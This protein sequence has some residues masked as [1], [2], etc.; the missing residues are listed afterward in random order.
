[1]KR[2]MDCN[3]EYI[4]QNGG[5]S[6]VVRRVC[7]GDMFRVP[8]NLVRDFIEEGTRQDIT[9]EEVSPCT[10][11]CTATHGGISVSKRD[12]IF[13]GDVSYA[14]PSYVL[15]GL[16]RRNCS[17]TQKSFGSDV[18]HSAEVVLS[19]KT[20]KLV[21]TELHEKNIFPE[22]HAPFCE[23]RFTPAQFAML[24]TNMNIGDGVPGTLMKREGKSIRFQ[25]HKE[26][27][28]LEEGMSYFKKVCKEQAEK[29][30]ELA[31]TVDELLE[32][33]NLTKED[34]AKL[35]GAITSARRTFDDS[36]PFAASQFQRH[37]EKV[38]TSAK[39]D[40][41][42]AMTNAMVGLGRDALLAG[43]DKPASGLPA[44]V[45]EFVSLMRNEDEEGADKDD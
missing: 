1:M 12:N 34:R 40:I 45:H 43:G 18:K 28:L 29:F 3:N 16:S 4:R 8:E 23:V 24:I 25:P 11:Q 39:I 27:S 5:L 37:A 42:A 22:T 6:S 32:K 2:I 44:S 36:M 14:H 9:I 7:Y 19:I 21:E 17:E 13:R 33:K 20:A 26:E 31:A 30:D 15:V 41:H 10:L 35:R 38:T